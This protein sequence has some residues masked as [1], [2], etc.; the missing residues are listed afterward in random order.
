M[1]WPRADLCEK[2]QGNIRLEGEYTCTWRVSAHVGAQGC[3]QVVSAGGGSAQEGGCLP[4]RGDLCPGGGMS[5]QEG[6]SPWGCVS[7]TGADPPPHCEQN[8]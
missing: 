3:P 6:V 5:A 7:H 2:L 1:W 4:R 8:D